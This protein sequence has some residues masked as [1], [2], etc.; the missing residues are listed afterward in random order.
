LDQDPLLAHTQRCHAYP[1]IIE[2]ENGARILIAPQKNTYQPKL[3]RISSNPKRTH[4]EVEIPA[5]QK[6]KKTTELAK[7]HTPKNNI[8]SE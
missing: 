1:V 4:T 7:K 6:T 5:C 2:K 3:L 8:S